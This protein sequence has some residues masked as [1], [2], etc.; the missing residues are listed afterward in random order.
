MPG[1]GY[2]FGHSR[3]R[4]FAAGATEVADTITQ[5]GVTFTFAAP[6]PVG[7][8]ANGDWWVLGP[9]SITSITP[10]SE[11]VRTART[12]SDFYMTDCLVRLL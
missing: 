5:H 8:Y 10:E 3:R 4:N 12:T 11:V 2:G 1:F 6:R 7:Q 9:V